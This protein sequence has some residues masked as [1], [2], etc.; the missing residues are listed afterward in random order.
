M[1]TSEVLHLGF[2]GSR[3][4]IR[5]SAY[6]KKILK[7]KCSLA[8]LPAPPTGISLTQRESAEKALE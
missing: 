7:D 1:P 8:A 3:A 4:G 5:T 2:W 6:P